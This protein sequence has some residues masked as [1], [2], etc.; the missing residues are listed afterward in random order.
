MFFFL[1]RGYLSSFKCFWKWQAPRSQGA[2]LAVL[3]VIS[4]SQGHKAKSACAVDRVLWK[5]VVSEDEHIQNN[6]W[7]SLSLYTFLQLMKHSINSEPSIEF[8][9][10]RCILT[11]N[12]WLCF[13][14]HDL[15]LVGSEFLAFK[16]R[17]I[18]IH[19]LAW[20]KFKGLWTSKLLFLD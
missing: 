1:S 14:L 10:S 15:F 7:E 18:D 12:L 8:H 19:I 13:H 3:C 5:Y 20:R 2:P 16:F 9:A 17:P 4:R 11:E 6:N